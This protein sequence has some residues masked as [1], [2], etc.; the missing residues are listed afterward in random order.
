MKKISKKCQIAIDNGQD[1]F[2]G[3]KC[4]MCGGTTRRTTDSSCVKCFHHKCM[5]TDLEKRKHYL[6]TKLSQQAR[7]KKIPFDICVDDIEWV[8]KCP[9]LGYNL[10]YFSIGGR[11]FNT[12]SFDKK[13]PTKGYTKGNV[14]IISNRANSIKSDMSLEQLERL[15]EYVKT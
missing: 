3:N 9:I 1:T 10:D 14:F 11:K 5:H 6:I 15:L 13:D 12:V 7:M 2:E 8:D 4:Y